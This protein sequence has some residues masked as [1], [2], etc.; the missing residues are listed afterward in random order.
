M[1]MTMCSSFLK[2]NKRF[3]WVLVILLPLCRIIEQIAYIYLRS[4]CIINY[5]VSS[6]SCAKRR[7]PLGNLLGFCFNYIHAHERLSLGEN[8][9]TT[10]FGFRI[11]M[12]NSCHLVFPQ[13]LGCVLVTR[14]GV[15]AALN[16]S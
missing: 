10:I 3:P 14:V 8:N 2:V 4:L 16:S 9:S 15:R 1:T 6:L 7:C 11:M 5:S 13:T 12:S